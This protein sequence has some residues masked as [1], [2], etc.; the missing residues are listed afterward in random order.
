MKIT[1]GV[2]PSLKGLADTQK[3]P[4]VRVPD[5]GLNRTDALS[6]SAVPDKA[7]VKYLQA[8][9]D[10]TSELIEMVDHYAAPAP[11]VQTGHVT[12]KG[13]PA[14]AP[15]VVVYFPPSGQEN[16]AV[17]DKGQLIVMNKG[18]LIR[19][20]DASGP[21]TD[22]DVLTL[23]GDVSRAL[24]PLM[25]GLGIPAGR[26]DLPQVGAKLIAV[27]DVQDDVPVAQVIRQDEAGRLEAVPPDSDSR[28]FVL[29]IV[30][31]ISADL[32]GPAGAN[33]PTAD[34]SEVSGASVLSDPAAAIRRVF[35][36]IQGH[37]AGT[38]NR[39]TTAGTAK[40][41][42][43]PAGN[44]MTA[45]GMPENSPP[46]TNLIPDDASLKTGAGTVVHYLDEPRGPVSQ[47][48]VRGADFVTQIADKMVV[49]ERRLEEVPY[50]RGED[51][52]L[53]EEDPAL[54]EKTFAALKENTAGLVRRALHAAV[55]Q[56]RS[57]YPGADVSALGI[58]LDENGFLKVDRTALS[59]S[60][61]ARKDE[62]VMFVRDLGNSLQDRIRYDFNPLAGLFA[63]NGNADGVLETGKKRGTADEGDDKPRVQ[64][65]TRL[66]E[67]QMLLK[68]SYELKDLFLQGGSSDQPGFFDETDR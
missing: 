1:L 35:S 13:Q 49:L 23:S 64:L 3:R 54:L 31:T 41:Q 33:E 24:S 61:S 51:T 17:P 40:R 26:F 27:L 38:G 18:A 30:K 45:A 65:E 11:A 2:Y 42:D 52:S 9:D 5:A 39:E 28:S 37:F 46:A 63:G 48:S 6:F 56:V 67:V 7:V 59:E 16:A 21:Q 36:A 44:G 57:E 34:K 32:E 62:A 66:N 43:V 20:T 60:L 22:N 10:I 29:D 50:F 4:S 58:G 55:S 68:S 47:A 25:S 53:P 8:I 12:L 14:T 15:A 19:G